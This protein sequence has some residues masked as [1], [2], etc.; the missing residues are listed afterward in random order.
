MSGNLQDRLSDVQRQVHTRH[1]FT[2]RL[3]TKLIK[4]GTTPTTMRRIGVVPGGT[5]EG[6]RLSGRVLDGGSDWQSIRGD[7][8]TLL[9]VRLS[10]E[11]Q[12]GAIICMTYIGV[13]HGPRDILQRL[14]AG[15]VVDPT[16]YYFRI[17][18]FFETASETHSWLNG[19]VAV[20]IGHRFADGPIYSVFELL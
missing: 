4:V 16:S 6:E 2:M 19:I 1:L 10:L 13:R 11:T 7:G 12:D 18:P 5:F 15:E 20:G 14:E 3:E 8:S 9:D 17:A